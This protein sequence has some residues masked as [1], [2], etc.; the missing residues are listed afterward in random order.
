MSIL[1]WVSILFSVTEPVTD[2]FIGPMTLDNRQTVICGSPVYQLVPG[3][4]QFS[5]EVE[6]ADGNILN[7]EATWELLPY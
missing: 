5:I 4:N 7:N 6:L 3:Q 1:G 2:C